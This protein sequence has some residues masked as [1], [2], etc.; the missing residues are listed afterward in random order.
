MPPVRSAALGS[1]LCEASNATAFHD[2]LA[3]N[4]P[5]RE[6]AIRVTATVGVITGFVPS[7]RVSVR[8]RNHQEAGHNWIRVRGRVII[9][10]GSASLNLT[11]AFHIVG[12]HG[13]G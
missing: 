5:V 9:V 1:P 6:Q 8:V 3:S 10:L 12:M 7:V 2:I 13:V 4:S 11:L